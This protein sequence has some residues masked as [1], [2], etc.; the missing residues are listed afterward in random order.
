MGKVIKHL[1]PS[2]W[3]VGWFSPTQKRTCHYKS[4]LQ[5][6]F[7]LHWFYN[8]ENSWQVLAISCLGKLIFMAWGFFICYE[9]Q[10]GIGRRWVMK[11]WSDPVRL[12]RSMYSV[13]PIHY[14]HSPYQHCQ[15]RKKEIS[16]WQQM[17]AWLNCSSC[18]LALKLNWLI[19]WFPRV[20]LKT[21]AN[22]CSISCM[23]VTLLRAVHTNLSNP[24]TDPVIKY[25]Y[26]SYFI[27][28][29]SWD[30]SLVTLPRTISLWQKWNS[31]PAIWPKSPSSHTQ[32]CTVGIIPLYRSFTGIWI[33]LLLTFGLNIHFLKHDP[34]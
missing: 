34:P 19:W 8:V 4:W 27:H 12:Q 16:P 17:I 32:C 13:L 6:V 14:F 28:L 5:F 25:H 29:E 15:E 1:P 26:Y 10:E 2:F 20:Y 3:P 24:L 11:Y 23:P 33:S 21:A 7:Q 9:Y 31:G 30:I 18:S 22:T